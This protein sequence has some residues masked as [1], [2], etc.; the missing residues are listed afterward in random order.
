MKNRRI[1]RL[2]AFLLAGSTIVS[3]AALAAGAANYM[4]DMDGDGK[5]TAFD[6]Q[7]LAE[8][9]AGKRQLEEDRVEAVG[10]NLVSD[11]VSF[12]LGKE[13]GTVGK[14]YVPGVVSV[15]SADELMLMQQ[16]PAKEYILMEDIDMTGV[17]WT[18]VVGFSGKFDGNGHTISNL[19]I[20][21]PDRMNLGFFGD[22]TADAVIT[23]LALRNVTLKASEDNKYIGIISGTCRGTVTGHTVTGAIYDSRTVMENEENAGESIVIGAMFGRVMGGSGVHTGGTGITVTD[24]TGK[25]SVSGLC[26]DI[27]LYIQKSS[28]SVL[29]KGLCGWK[30]SDCGKVSGQWRDS[31]NCAENE[32]DVMRA[33]QDTVVDYM[34][35]MATVA[36]QVPEILT[37]NNEYPTGEHRQVYYPGTTYYG[38]PYNHRNGG[39]E[40]F[41]SCAESVDANGV[42]MMQEG[43]GNSTIADAENMTGFAT[44]MGN[45]CSSAVGWAWMQISP[46]RVQGATE[47]ECA[48]GAY[49]NNT[50]VMV[51]TDTVIRAQRTDENGNLAY[52]YA[53]TDASGETRSLRVYL[54]DGKLY[55]VAADGTYVLGDLDGN[56]ISVDDANLTPSM[57]IV[58]NDV[59]GTYGI[60]PVGNWTTNTYLDE[61]G[62]PRCDDVVGEFAYAIPEYVDPIEPDTADFL[63][64]NTDQQMAEAYALT[65]KADGLVGA[66]PTGHARLVTSYPVT[67]RNADGTINLNKSFLVVTEQGEGY[68]DFKDIIE[69]AEGSQA[70]YSNWRVDFRFTYYNLLA[71]DSDARLDTEDGNPTSVGARYSKHVYLPI[72]IRALRSEY[73]K[74]GYI[75]EAVAVTGPYTG[76]IYSNWR[77][78]SSKVSILNGSG[79]ELFSKTVYTGLSGSSGEDY[80]HG[81]CCYVTLDDHYTDWFS[82]TAPTK[83]REGRTYYYRVEV[84]LANGQTL[85]VSRDSNKVSANGHSGT[86]RDAFTYTG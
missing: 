16:Y 83:L 67:I 1:K 46:N 48:G 27:K 41:L 39:M 23:D 69:P 64:C 35:E 80:N 31:T 63:T 10:R 56:E 36:W 50:Q 18:P 30:A 54:V 44:M 68:F 29:H 6:A 13:A 75:D 12:L 38:L 37:Y 47:T 19:T 86:D 62:I 4:G 15:Y 20:E 21:A 74:A 51:P 78:V 24:D 71:K 22:T 79:T 32:S 53:Y 61:K 81:V 59:Q 42:Y 84:L 43:L 25:H 72:T 45:D 9:N 11:I 57:Q 33:R 8:V 7:I 2:L 49:V 70:S 65:R 77:I 82:E 34:N 17:V 14:E 26:G 55:H 52:N 3:A 40:R 28:E 60:Y 58:V 85:I 66:Q 76:K 73:V 5:I